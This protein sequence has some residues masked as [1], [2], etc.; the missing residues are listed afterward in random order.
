MK[1][2]LVSLAVLALGFTASAQAEQDKSKLC[3]CPSYYMEAFNPNFA[4]APLVE[5]QPAAA[6][7]CKE[8]IRK[9]YI[10]LNGGAQVF[11]GTADYHLPFGKAIAPVGGINFGRYINHWLNIDLNLT[12]AQFKGLYNRP[13][14]DKHFATENC[15]DLDAQRYYQQGAYL[16]LYAR[17]GFDLNT[18]F[19]G[20]KPCR[21]TSFVPY[22]GGGIATGLGKNCADASNFG[23]VPTID[24]GLEFLIRFC[25]VC[26]GVID[27]HGNAVGIGLDNEN[28][29]VHAFHSSYGAKLGVRFNLGN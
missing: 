29:T 3:D 8:G 20:Y 11:S 7:A 28:C 27:L 16:Q 26:T 22:V 23:I 21:K 10:G 14:G 15:F 5:E 19:G 13:V 25:P 1:K 6:P 24:Y 12:A 2:L 9:W 4:E 17:A 18:I